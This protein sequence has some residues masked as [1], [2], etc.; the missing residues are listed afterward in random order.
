[1]DERLNTVPCGF[2]S[3][4]EELKIAEVNT[5]L[6]ILLGYSEQTKLKG[7]PINLILSGPSRI[8]FNIYFTPLATLNNRVDEMFLTLQTTTGENLPVLLNAARHE[9]NGGMR[10]E[11]IVFPIRRQLEYEQQVNKAENAAVKAKYKLELL[12]ASITHKQ[13]IAAKLEEQIEQYD[14]DLL[15]KKL[16]L[17]A[18]RVELAQLKRS[19]QTPGDRGNER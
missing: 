9:I 2:V 16:E 1:M 10:Y 11:C 3:L 15:Q 5:T 13:Q 4:T 6:L 7:Q 12:Q 17:E 18:I 19:S 14:Q 8:F